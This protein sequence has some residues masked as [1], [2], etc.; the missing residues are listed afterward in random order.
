MLRLS[1]TDLIP[2]EVLPLLLKLFS[3]SFDEA[4][5][6]TRTFIVKGFLHVLPNSDAR[7]LHIFSSTGVGHKVRYCI[8]E[9]FSP[10][11]R[12][13]YAAALAILDELFEPEDLLGSPLEN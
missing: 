1:I 6:E 4:S 10:R 5:F 11:D 3:D 9:G 13:D 12:R 2:E 8:E 7:M